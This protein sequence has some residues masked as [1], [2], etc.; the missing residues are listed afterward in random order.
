MFWFLAFIFIFNLFTLC[1]VE[2]IQS[3]MLMLILIL[4]TSTAKYTQQLSKKNDEDENKVIENY[5][6]FWSSTI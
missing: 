3:V 4:I 1:N 6:L 2:K 5:P